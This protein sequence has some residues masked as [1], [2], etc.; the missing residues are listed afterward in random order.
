MPDSE[1]D[2]TPAQRDA[3]WPE[4]EPSHGTLTVIQGGKSEPMSIAEAL[5]PGLR[6]TFGCVTEDN[7]ELQS[8]LESI[9][10]ADARR[11]PREDPEP[12]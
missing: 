10:R 3:G 9:R 6:D 2:V 1:P 12:V 8:A 5:T 11:L 7:P 4:P